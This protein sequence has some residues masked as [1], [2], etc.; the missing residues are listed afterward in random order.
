MPIAYT[1]DRNHSVRAFAGK[2]LVGYATAWLDS[3][4]CFV[5]LASEVR[6][7]YRRRGIATAMYQMIENGAGRAL[8]PAASLSDDAFRFWCRYRP[9]AVA[10]DLRHQPELI[11]AKAVLAGRTGRIVKASG[12]VATVE[13]DDG[14]RSSGLQACIIREDLPSALSVRVA[15]AW[16]S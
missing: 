13:F 1:M 2:L 5:I 15:G 16:V 4:G 7:A 9:S 12:R 10:A 14:D 6:P 11:G 8:S 3:R